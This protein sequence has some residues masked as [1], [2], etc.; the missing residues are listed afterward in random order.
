MPRDVSQ[1][2]R[3]EAYKDT[4]PSIWHVLLSVN[5]VKDD[6]DVFEGKYV[7][8]YLPVQSRGSVFQPAAFSV[9]IGSDISD[10]IPR[11]KLDFDAG[12]RTLIRLLRENRNPPKIVLEVVMSNTPDI[13]EIGPVEFQADSFSIKASAVNM[14]LTV[15]PIL[16]EPVPSAK[17]TPTLFPGL[18]ENVTV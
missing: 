5:L 7:N 11:T 18:F 10:T 14:D 16:N 3:E 8:D 17:F 2:F 1:L 9:S 4:T 6:G 13:V 12:D 15:E